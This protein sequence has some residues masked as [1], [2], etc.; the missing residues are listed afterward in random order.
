MKCGH[1]ETEVNL[2]NWKPIYRTCD[3]YVCSPTCSRERLKVIFRL[4]PDLTQCIEWANIRTIT[5]PK[6]LSKKPSYVA[7]SLHTDDLEDTMKTTQLHNVQKIYA[8]YDQTEH[9]DNVHSNALTA[10]LLCALGTSLSII[11]MTAITINVILL[12]S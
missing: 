2:Y 8:K 10:L 1:C 11:C 7:L 6:T 4:D 9:D 12:L 3:A 5:P